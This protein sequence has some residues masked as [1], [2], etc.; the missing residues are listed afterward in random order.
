MHLHLFIAAYTV[1]GFCSL[2]IF[3][4]HIALGCLRKR[5]KIYQ[6]E[7]GCYNCRLWKR[8][9]RLRLKILN[10]EKEKNNR[11]RNFWAI[12]LIEKSLECKTLFNQMKI[13]FFLFF[14]FRF[15]LRSFFVAHVSPNIFCLRSNS[16][17]FCCM[18]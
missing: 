12:F 17:S 7:W 18:H 4:N 5:R 9:N 13:R 10:A 8:N 14:S 2:F 1:S 15:Y 11:K 3:C 16:F 6:Q